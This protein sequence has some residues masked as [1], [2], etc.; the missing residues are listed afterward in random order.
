MEAEGGRESDFVGR[1]ILLAFPTITFLM[2]QVVFMLLH[3]AKV[4]ISKL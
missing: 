2:H 1:F 3:K 4:V